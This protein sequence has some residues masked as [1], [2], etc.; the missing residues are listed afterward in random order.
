MATNEPKSVKKYL[1]PG[2]HFQGQSQGQKV[3]AVKMRPTPKIMMV[4]D[5][6]ADSL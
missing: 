5:R 1:E 3:M 4:L 6:L 2:G